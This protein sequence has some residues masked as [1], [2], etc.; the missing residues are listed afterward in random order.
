[1]GNEDV[2]NGCFFEL[3]FLSGPGLPSSDEPHPRV[4]NF[5]LPDGLRGS[6]RMALATIFPRRDPQGKLASYTKFTEH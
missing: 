3:G 5:P 6:F 2:R 1:M 4:S